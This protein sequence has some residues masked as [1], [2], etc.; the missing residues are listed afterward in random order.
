MCVCLHIMV[1]LMC[2][3]CDILL[4]CVIYVIQG[5]VPGELFLEGS[6][7][8]PLFELQVFLVFAEALAY[9]VLPTHDIIV[10]CAVI[11]SVLRYVYCVVRN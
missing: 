3:T 7:P 10:L 4:G 9:Y 2:Y 8:S 11:Y 5:G 1:R 6:S